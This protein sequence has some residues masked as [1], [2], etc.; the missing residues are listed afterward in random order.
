MSDIDK[1]T[2]LFLDHLN[3][4]IEVF[5]S[6]LKALQRLHGL[7]ETQ[8]WNRLHGSLIAEVHRATGL[9]NKYLSIKH[10]VSPS[11]IGQVE[12]SLPA[13]PSSTQIP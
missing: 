6:H 10:P 5:S 3:K 8:E 4:E 1:A 11:V 2:D 9:R 7:V 12:I 13:P